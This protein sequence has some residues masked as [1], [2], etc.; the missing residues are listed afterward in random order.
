MFIGS[1]WERI[2][3]VWDWE[4]YTQGGEGCD[5]LFQLALE[6][7]GWWADFKKIKQRCWVV[8]ASWKDIFFK[9]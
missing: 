5:S 1:V 4:D 8:A 7:I 6:R 2:Q 3:L 9:W